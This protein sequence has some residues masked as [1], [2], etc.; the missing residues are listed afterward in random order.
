MRLIDRS[1]TRGEP[2]SRHG[3]LIEQ[4]KL[5]AVGTASKCGA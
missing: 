3:I 1:T 5:L 4:P 2:Q